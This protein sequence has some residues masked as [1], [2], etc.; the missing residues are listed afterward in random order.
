[1][2]E[3]V[4]VVD[5]EDIALARELF[6]EYLEA[7][8][9]ETGLPNPEESPGVLEWMRADIEALPV[10]YVPPD[11]ALLVARVGD[12]VAGS[13]G[14]ARVDATTTELRRLWVRPS[15]RRAGVARALT[16]ASLE[17]AADLGYERIVLDV[18]PSRTGAIDLY[19]SLGF[20]EIEPYDEYPFPMVFLGRDLRTGR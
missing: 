12:A 4:A 14:L 3:P 2:S 18:V 16:V 7:T 17:R 1:M 5:C 20:T 8:I 11:G 13:V 15:F 10:P 9:E 19:R 6:T